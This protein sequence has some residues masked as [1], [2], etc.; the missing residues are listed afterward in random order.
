MNGLHEGEILLD[1]SAM[2]PPE[3]LQRAT[4]ILQQLEP[5]QYLRMLHRRLP[6]PLFDACKSLAI[7]HRHFPGRHS[8]WVILFW[9]HEDSATAQYC[10]KLEP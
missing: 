3:P 5:G 10:R 7:D 9:R 4:V 6:Y 1:A 2:E 8:H